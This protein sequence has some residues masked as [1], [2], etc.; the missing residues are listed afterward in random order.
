MINQ[1]GGGSWFP[2]NCLPIVQGTCYF[3][4]SSL[5]SLPAN[6]VV[7]Y[8]RNYY[9]LPGSRTRSRLGEVDLGI[10]N[11][12]YA[13]DLSASADVKLVSVLI[14]N[15]CAFSS[16]SSSMMSTRRYLTVFTS[17]LDDV[18]KACI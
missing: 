11:A 14:G 4:K 17:F 5:G 9:L 13:F 12:V 3:G 15:A 7:P 2:G 1:I 10:W 8:A 16:I 18:K 6:F